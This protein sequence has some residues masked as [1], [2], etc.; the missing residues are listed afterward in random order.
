[1][2]RPGGPSKGLR[3]RRAGAGRWVFDGANPIARRVGPR[4]LGDELET[5][6]QCH[7]RRSDL[8]DGPTTAVPFLDAHRPALLDDGLYCADGQ[9]LDEVYVWGSFQQSRMR[10]AGV[11]CSDCHDP[12]ALTLRAEGNDLCARRH[13]PAHYDDPAHHL[14]P[15]D[16]PGSRCEACHMPSRTY[17]GVDVRHDHGFR[18]PRPDLSASLGTPNPCTTCHA[19]RDAAW[20]ADVLTRRRGGRA[21]RPH[22]GEAIAAGRDGATD[23]EAKL[24][25][26]VSAAGEPAIVRATAVSL[27]AGYAGPVATQTLVAAASADEPLLR[28][29]AADAL[30]GRD[31]Q[32]VIAALGP[33]L[34]DP[35][36]AVRLEAVAS[37]AAVADRL[38]PGELAEA[39]AAAEAEHR[40]VQLAAADRPEAQLSLALFA[41]RRGQVAE[42]E[43]MLRTAIRLAPYF[44]PASIN[45]AD[46]YRMQGRDAEAE[47]VLRALLAEAPDNADA[48]HALGLLLVRSDRAGEALETFRRAATLAPED[49]RHAYVL[50]VALYSLGDVAGAL[51]VLRAAHERRPGDVDVLAALTTMSRDSG[52]VGAARRWAGRLVEVVPW[53]T[54]A[55]RLQA[56]IEA[57]PSP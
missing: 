18:V 48:H 35:V 9:I 53:D 32:V 54:G 31:P 33:L 13:A 55:R 38:P 26:L 41:L 25:A 16:S 22:F 4:H 17:M 37:L 1:V 46:L 29:A 43:Q 21:P 36:R 19:D 28:L 20:A 45:L 7:A 23:A 42:A 5:C 40:A 27:L 11:T 50:G 6:A 51:D 2:P 3:V 56:E 44:V 39:F 10:A 34:R 52:D 49:T 24:V 12:H 8:G 47:P 30:D 14:H 15:A 57:A